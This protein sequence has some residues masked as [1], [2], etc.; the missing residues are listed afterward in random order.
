MELFLDRIFGIYRDV[1]RLHL[2]QPLASRALPPYFANVL[3]SY[4]PT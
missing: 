3:V 1:P 2:S 4:P